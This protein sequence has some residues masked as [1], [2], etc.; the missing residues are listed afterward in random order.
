[1]NPELQRNLLL[2]QGY[3]FCWNQRFDCSNM[4][5]PLCEDRNLNREC[6]TSSWS[7]GLC[8][9][10]ISYSHLHNPPFH[11]SLFGIPPWPKLWTIRASCASS[12]MFHDQRADESGCLKRQDTNW[13]SATGWSRTFGTKFMVPRVISW[14]AQRILESLRRFQV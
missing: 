8:Q 2:L 12:L 5:S 14:T 9:K 4:V 13:Q 11:L 3:H 6:P 10:S 7:L 1:M